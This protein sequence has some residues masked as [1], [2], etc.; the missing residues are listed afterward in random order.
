MC[1]RGRECGHVCL[2]LYVCVCFYMSVCV[3]FI[4]LY[5]SLCFIVYVCTD[6]CMSM[7]SLD[8]SSKIHSA[9]EPIATMC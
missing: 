6:A 3:C 7:C 1:V 8:A 5:V 4:C 9:A 2:F